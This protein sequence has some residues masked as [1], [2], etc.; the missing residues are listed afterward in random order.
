MFEYHKD[1]SPC[2]GC[3]GKCCHHLPGI[4]LPEQVEDELLAGAVCFTENFPEHLLID[5]WEPDGE[6]DEPIY[7][8][9][10]NFVDMEIGRIVPSGYYDRE[11]GDWIPLDNGMAIEILSIDG[12]IAKVDFSN[13]GVEPRNPVLAAGH[14]EPFQADE[15]ADEVKEEVRIRHVIHNLAGGGLVGNGHRPRET[16][17]VMEIVVAEHPPGHMDH[18]LDVH[19]LGE[20]PGGQ[21]SKPRLHAHARS[22]PD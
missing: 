10:E 17:A 5:W 2:A 8:Y 12:D 14:A 13:D 1:S 16:G 22:I 11:S 19:G 20:R 4:Y 3:G 15:H 6:F 18:L 7:Y 21:C 9:V